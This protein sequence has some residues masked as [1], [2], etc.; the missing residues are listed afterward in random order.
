MAATARATGQILIRKTPMT[1][2]PRTLQASVIALLRMAVGWHFLYEGIAKLLTPNWSAAGYL[3]AS[4]WVFAGFF[5]WVSATP[6]ILKVVDFINIWA[7]IGVGLALMLGA[8][9]TAAS[10]VGM[11]LVMAYWLANPPLAGLGLTVPTEGSYVLVDKNVVEF[12][13]LASLAVLQAGRCFGLDTLIFRDKVASR[14]LAPAKPSAAAP[15]L[16]NPAAKA[17]EGV[18]ASPLPELPTLSRSRSNLQGFF[19]KDG[20]GADL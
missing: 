14:E 12:F 20:I 13:G 7:L 3:D 18:P 10:V 1:N 2:P 9:T 11:A 4:R 5:H 15:L 19:D 6:G 8:F 17:S 16:P